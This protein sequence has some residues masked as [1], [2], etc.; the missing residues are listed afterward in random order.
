V[1]ASPTQFSPC[2]MQRNV[3]NLAT[4][5]DMNVMSCME[6]AVSGERQSTR[7]VFSLPALHLLWQLG[8]WRGAHMSISGCALRGTRCWHRMSQQN[9]SGCGRDQLLR[10]QKQP[11]MS[12]SLAAA[13]TST[14]GHID[15]GRS[16]ILGC[17]RFF[18]AVML[19]GMLLPK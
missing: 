17:P 11:C 8:G 9:L 3:G 7:L 16:R 14:S 1:R 13:R 5:K 6:Y 15:G 18:V 19:P 10:W 12:D 2:A 4:H